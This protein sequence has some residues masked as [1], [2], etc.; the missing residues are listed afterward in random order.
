MESHDQ[1]GYHV[2]G[3]INAVYSEI[4]MNIIC[5]NITY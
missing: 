3:D 4:V 5:K 1:R 2:L